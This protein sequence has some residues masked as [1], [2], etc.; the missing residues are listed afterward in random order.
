MA[1]GASMVGTVGGAIRGPAIMGGAGMD[2]LASGA[3]PTVMGAMVGATEEE[4]MAAATA[5]K[6]F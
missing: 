4:A 2:T 1:A 6:C 5:D 3:A